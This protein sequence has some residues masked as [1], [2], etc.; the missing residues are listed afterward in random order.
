MAMAMSL[1]GSK[2]AHLAWGP[3]NL[4]HCHWIG[5][6]HSPKD[7]NKS[8]ELKARADLRKA[9]LCTSLFSAPQCMETIAFGSLY[10]LHSSRALGVAPASTW[11]SGESCPLRPPTLPWSRV[12]P[13]LSGIQ[14]S[15]GGSNFNWEH[16][17][18]TLRPKRSH[19]CVLQGHPMQPVGHFLKPCHR[20]LA[21]GTRDAS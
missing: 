18:E 1:Q 19:W 11:V 21:F 7:L 20:P 9:T 16:T 15:P 8:H 12:S 2:H 14:P 3:Q 17:F 10:Q 4:D 13:P 6:S 5:I